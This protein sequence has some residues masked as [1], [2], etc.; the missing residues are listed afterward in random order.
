MGSLPGRR[1]CCPSCRSV[2]MLAHRCDSCIVLGPCAGAGSKSDKSNQL[3]AMHCT[4]QAPSTHCLLFM[5]DRHRQLTSHGP[6]LPH[7]MCLHLP[8]HLS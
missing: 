7:C 8:C 5:S 2:H 4:L 3:N 1:W 6:L